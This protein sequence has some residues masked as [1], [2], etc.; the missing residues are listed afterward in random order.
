M[1]AVVRV[2]ADSLV[3]PGDTLWMSATVKINISPIYVT[4]LEI[5]IVD[6][7]AYVEFGENAVSII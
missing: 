7:S 1:E 4:Q 3:V 6:D 5:T 2:E